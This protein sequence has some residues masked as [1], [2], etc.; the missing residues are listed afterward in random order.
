LAAGNAHIAVV[1]DDPKIRTVLRK[2]LEGEG[3]R[4]S[5]AG[6]SAEL[7]S[8][9]AVEPVSLITLDLSLGQEDGLEVARR[10]RSQSQ[11]PIIMVTG[12]GDMIDR[13]VGLEIGADDY[14]AKPFHLREVL[15]RIRTVL[16]RAKSERTEAALP[17]ASRSTKSDF[18]FE[19][20]KLD[21]VKRELY[22]PAGNQ[23]DLTTAE[24]DLLLLF[25]KR[26]G[27]V[28]SRDSIMTLLKGQDWA[29]NDRAIDTMVARLRKK[30]GGDSPSRSLIKTIRGIGYQFTGKVTQV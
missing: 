29:A 26:S 4:V 23:S 24:F 14:I 7:F 28:L 18:Y 8:I 10:I 6:G 9:L 19:G 3:Y 13:V 15:A 30:I 2:C 21:P 1:D 20:W 27:H 11:V 16:R 22:S 25:V 12:K 5:E 17:D